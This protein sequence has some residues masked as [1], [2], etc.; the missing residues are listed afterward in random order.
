VIQGFRVRGIRPSSV[1]FLTEES[2]RWPRVDA[3]KFRS[4][5]PVA[6]SDE[7]VRAFVASNRLALGL[8]PRAKLSILPIEEARFTSP[9]DVPHAFHFTQVAGGNSGAGVS[10]VFEAC[11]RLKY[12]IATT[13]SPR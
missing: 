5:G 1:A 7:A 4:E 13:R 9:D 11:G 10:L 6:L 8:P 12:A 2:L 3:S